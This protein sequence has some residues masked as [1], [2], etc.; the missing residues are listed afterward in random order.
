MV[1]ILKNLI[2]KAYSEMD[3]FMF[4]KEIL[5]ICTETEFPSSLIDSHL[6]ESSEAT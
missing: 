5:R 1:H 2:K 4:D 3:R 6:Q